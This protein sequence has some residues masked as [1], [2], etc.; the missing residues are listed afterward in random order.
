MR[1]RSDG[2]QAACG[3]RYRSAAAFL[4][5]GIAAAVQVVAAAQ[6]PDFTGVWST[7][8]PPGAKPAIGG[9]RGFGPR[10]P[11]PFTAE[12]QRRHD[13]Y[14]KLLGPEQANPGAYCVDYGMPMMMEMAGGYP[15]EFIQKGDQLTIIFEV[16]GET[17]RV[18]LGKRGVPEEKRLTTRDGYSVG[19]WDG[20]SLVVETSD[21]T[22]G[23]DQFHPHSEQAHISER[24]T[25]SKDARGTQIMEYS[26]SMTD[27][28]YY[29]Q[30]VVVHS[31]WAR[32]PEGYLMTYRCP[33]EF[34]LDLLKMRR[35]QLQAGKPADAKMSDVY[36][37]RED[38]Q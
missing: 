7:Y 30:P 1:Y 2:W 13:E 28:V 15:L 25:V 24:F 23:V 34:W 4:A 32:V 31:K 6:P 12:G 27:P 5:L 37:A 19:H 17:R 36:K 33:D 20:N 16:E 26:M 29:T 10:A 21:L 11:L 9:G 8:V 18:F 38:K 22:D 35:E 14:N 3:R